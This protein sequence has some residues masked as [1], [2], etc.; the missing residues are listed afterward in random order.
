[1]VAA[2]L[3]GGCV[4]TTPGRRRRRGSVIRVWHRRRV[5]ARHPARQ[6]S[7]DTV[8]GRARPKPSFDRQVCVDVDSCLAACGA[9]GHGRARRRRRRG[10]AR[11]SRA[12]W[13]CRS[14]AR[15][16]R[17]RPPLRGSSRV[18]EVWPGGAPARMRRSAG[19]STQDCPQWR[20]RSLQPG[21]DP[22]ATRSVRT[23]Q[24]LSGRNPSET[25]EHRHDRRRHPG[26][27]RTGL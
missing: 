20:A 22:D 7:A 16:P 2:G 23:G 21:H 15:V 1:M 4:S 10:P 8:A 25:D 17:C 27:S 24:G 14:R 26:S 11:P 13:C 5:T 12:C 19:L 3:N 6:A 9:P 18:V